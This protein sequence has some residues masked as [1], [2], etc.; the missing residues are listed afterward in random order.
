L[1]IIYK[2]QFIIKIQHQVLV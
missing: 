2:L 1:T